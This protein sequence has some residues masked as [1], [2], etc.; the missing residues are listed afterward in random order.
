MDVGILVVR[1]ALGLVVAAHGAQK[2]F[3]I[4]GG[5]GIAGTSQFV[6]SLGFRPGRFYAY[7][8]G[9]GEFIGGSMLAA[10]L[11]TPVATLTV[12]AIMTAASVA[13][14]WRNGFFA[15]DGGFELPFVIAVVA[16]GIALTGPGYYSWDALLDLPVRGG[17]SIAAI[18]LGILLG[19]AIV[20]MRSLP[21]R[22]PFFRRIQSQS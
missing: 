11:F 20:G 15:T 14:H 1:V 12:I 22:V 7:L 13:V 5:H 8:L 3:G 18:G 4:F 21:E 2:L 17:V 6:E 19:V 9:I 10:G 16:A